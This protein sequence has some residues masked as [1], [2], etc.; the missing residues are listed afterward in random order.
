[1]YLDDRGVHAL[2]CAI[3][4]QAAIDFILYKKWLYLNEIGE[5]T[6]SGTHPSPYILQRDLDDVIDFFYSDMFKW[7]YPS[8][9]PAIL[10][11][12]LDI[13]VDKWV[14]DWEKN[15]DKQKHFKPNKSAAI[16]SGNKLNNR[17][18][19]IKKAK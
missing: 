4:E 17:R 1:M 2:S 15:H 12:E 13:M 3:V 14:D 16:T 5:Y 19:K 6:V 7:M 10:I 8:V 18:K 9:K 11:D